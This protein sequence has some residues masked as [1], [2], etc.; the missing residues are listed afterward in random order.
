MKQIQI[1]ERNAPN[2]IFVWKT[3]QSTWT[4]RRSAVF[5]TFAAPVS[6]AWKELKVYMSIVI[7]IMNA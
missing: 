6:Y 5:K 2:L 3:A 7:I 1:T 4:A